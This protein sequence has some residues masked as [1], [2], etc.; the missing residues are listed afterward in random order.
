V[1]DN[2]APGRPLA[3][4]DDPAVDQRAAANDQRGVVALRLDRPDVAFALEDLLFVRSELA[5]AFEVA[6]LGTAFWRTY[7][8]IKN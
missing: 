4:D 3:P 2:S 1:L 7:A 5:L 6:P 8:L